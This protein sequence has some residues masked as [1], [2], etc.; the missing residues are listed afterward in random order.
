MT[1]IFNKKLDTGERA[2]FQVWRCADC[3]CFHLKAGEA[4]MT[5]SPEE[6]ASFAEEIVECYSRQICRDE[7]SATTFPEEQEITIISETMN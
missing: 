3:R 7:A 2:E 5:F 4:L 1:A 6:F